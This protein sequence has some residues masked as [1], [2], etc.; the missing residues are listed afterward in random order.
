M[1][2]VRCS[3]ALAVLVV[4]SVAAAGT[5]GHAQ[6]DPATKEA[7]STTMPGVTGPAN[8]ALSDRY[9]TAVNAE[10]TSKVDSKNATAGQQVMA[11]TT[12]SATLADGTR[13]PKGTKLIGHVARVQA[14]SDV[15]PHAIL[16][17]AFDSAELKGGKTVALRS[18]IRA[19]AA[20][21]NFAAFANGDPM[22][23]AADAPM[24]PGTSASGRGGLGTGGGALG[25]TVRGVGQTAGGLG[26]AAGSTA[27][28]TARDTTALADTVADAPGGVVVQ[29]GDNLSEVP[30][31]T[32]LP[33]VMLA[34]SG[35]ANASG[36]LLASGRNISLESGTRIT[37]GL[38]TR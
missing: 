20:P 7:T 14:A 18:K 10:L 26:Q 2:A 23:D 6:D 35:S 17:V 34:T 1:N 19:V 11:R 33:G 4:L 36:T 16:A 8:A 38:I 24:G 22:A 31:A 13:L 25:G 5:A 3:L 12:E 27:G 32:A 9:M 37:L 29:A 21:A 30:R 15:Q 28:T